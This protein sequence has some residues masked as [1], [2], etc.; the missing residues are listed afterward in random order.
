MA[1]AVPDYHL[2]IQMLRFQAAEQVAAIERGRASVLEL[3]ARKLANDCNIA[4]AQRAI[5]ELEKSAKTATVLIE[6]Q[7]LLVQLAA[8]RSTIERQ[9]LENME[10]AER[11]SKHDEAIDAAQKAL[12]RFRGQLADLEK[13]HGDLTDDKY[14]ELRAILID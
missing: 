2:S 8:Q 7:R 11:A 13:A 5:S 6:K 4:A 3:V 1:D 9:R 14:R 12:K 10:G